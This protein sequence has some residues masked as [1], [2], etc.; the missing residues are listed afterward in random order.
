[1]SNPYTKKGYEDTFGQIKEKID[2]LQ[3]ITSGALIALAVGFISIF[4]S[5]VAIFYDAFTN[6]ASSYIELNNQVEDQN[7]K[8]EELTKQIEANTHKVDEVNSFFKE[9]E[10]VEE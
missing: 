10:L 7:K 5:T 6:K 1:M 2:W 9:I 8:I 3:K 4:I